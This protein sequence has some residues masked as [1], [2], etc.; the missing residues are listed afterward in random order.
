IEIYGFSNLK[1]KSFG[2]FAHL[3][4]IS[5]ILSPFILIIYLQ[6]KKG[7]HY[8]LSIILVFINLFLFGG[9]YGIFIALVHVIV[10][11]SICYN[12]SIRKTFIFGILTVLIGLI[13]FILVYAV[14]PFLFQGNFSTSSFIDSINFAVKHFL[15]YLLSPLIAT[16][17]YFSNGTNLVEGIQI[18]FTVPINII[19]AIFQTGGYIDPIN[20]NFVKVSSDL[21]TNVG[22]LFSESVF[23]SNL[24]IASIYVGIFFC[25]VYFFYIKTRYQGE[26]LSITSLL[27]AIVSLLFFTN[28]LTV[29]GVVLP[30]IFLAIFEFILKRDFSFEKYY[31]NIKR[32]FQN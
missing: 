2:I 3:G 21:R 5:V 17:Y 15:Y 28:F 26:F 22:G 7:Y 18:M 20:Y 1:G 12:I 11:Y 10:F 13:V 6:N 24:V 30:L 14:K 27:L 8:L 29:S 25:I 31:R 16:N 9:K 4:E 23:R 19:K 32:W